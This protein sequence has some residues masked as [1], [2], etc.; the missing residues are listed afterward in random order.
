MSGSLRLRVHDVPEDETA[1]EEVLR[2]EIG[3]NRQQLEALQQLAGDD[4]SIAEYIE[5]QFVELY[6]I[7]NPERAAKL[8]KASQG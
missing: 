3:F 4:C 1:G 2:A 7:T 8:M 6:E 5:R